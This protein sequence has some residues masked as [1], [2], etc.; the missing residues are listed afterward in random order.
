M[1]YIIIFCLV[2]L[3]AKPA[4]AFF[5]LFDVFDDIPASPK[6]QNT[7]DGTFFPYYKSSRAIAF[8]ESITGNEFSCEQFKTSLQR[9]DIEKRSEKLMEFLH[10]RV[11][12]C[13]RDGINGKINVYVRTWEDYKYALGAGYLTRKDDGE[14]E[15]PFDEFMENTCDDA[16]DAIN[17]SEGIDKVNTWHASGGADKERA[18]EVSKIRIDVSEYIQKECGSTI[19]REETKVPEPRAHETEGRAAI[20]GD[21]QERKEDDEK[22]KKREKKQ[23]ISQFIKNY[24]G[25]CLDS[26]LLSRNC[27]SDI[28]TI[29]DHGVSF[30]NRR[31]GIFYFSYDQLA[32]AKYNSSI[33]EAGW[34]TV[35]GTDKK[36]RIYSFDDFTEIQSYAIRIKQ[37]D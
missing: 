19:D 28:R 27:R 2:C 12:A 21:R 16:I 3:S 32:T 6:Y 31:E 8:I 24:Q 5:G 1:R 35:P 17:K 20:T 25:K 34:I 26:N 10:Q 33:I 30:W 9:Q 14:V 29:D 23:I 36:V 37:L 11:N 13:I 15:F 22:A 4:F 7:L 18:I